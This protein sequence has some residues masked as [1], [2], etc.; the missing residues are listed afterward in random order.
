MSSEHE[1][2]FPPRNSLDFD[3]DALC[4]AIRR[5]KVCLPAF[6][7]FHCVPGFSPTRDRQVTAAATERF[8]KPLP[9]TLFGGKGE[10][11]N[12]HFLQL[13]TLAHSAE[14][15]PPERVKLTWTCVSTSTGSP[16]S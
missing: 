14:V 13:R 10:G 16:F 7:S 9:P 6:D 3:F 8:G 5:T 15:Y 1:L 12:T 11:Q 4:D 2:L